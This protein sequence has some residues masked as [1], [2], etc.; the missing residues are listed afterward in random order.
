M[1]PSNLSP[2]SVILAERTSVVDAVPLLVYPPN[3]D[4]ISCT[5]TYSSFF[6]D[7]PD[8]KLRVGVESGPT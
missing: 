3:L 2:L 7:I 8:V 5:L 6:N 4:E 1:T